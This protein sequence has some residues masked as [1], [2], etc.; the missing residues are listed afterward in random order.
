MVPMT[1]LQTEHLILEPPDESLTKELQ[2]LIQRNMEHFASGMPRQVLQQSQPAFWQRKLE[3]EKELWQQGHEYNVYGRLRESGLLICHV[4]ISHVTRG[5]FQA[6]Y[7]GYK[8]DFLH[9]GQGLM[10]EALQSVI[11]FAFNS[12]KLHRLMA[13]HLPNNDRSGRLLHRL[14]FRQ[15]GYAERYLYLNGEW[16]DHVLNAID[17]PDFDTS[18]LDT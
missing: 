4:Q 18:K 13:N 7:L 3:K 6:A 12:L 16:R 5:I 1:P 15:E 2:Q 9:Q 8:I 17:N 14:H 10:Y 11:E